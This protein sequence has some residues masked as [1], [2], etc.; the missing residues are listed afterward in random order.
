MFYFKAMIEKEWDR[1]EKGKDKKHTNKN[2][3][4]HIYVEHLDIF[5]GKKTSRNKYKKKRKKI[6]LV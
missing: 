2:V 3:S 5:Q 6:L 4:V 1:E